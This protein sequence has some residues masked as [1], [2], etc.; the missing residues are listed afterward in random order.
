[1]KRVNFFPT[2]IRRLFL[3]VTLTASVFI[4]SGCHALIP[5]PAAAGLDSK[6]IKPKPPAVM[7]APPARPGIEPDATWHDWILLKDAVWEIGNTGV[8]VTVPAGF[9]T[10]LASSPRIAWPFGL[11]PTETYT[12][13]AIIHDYLYWTG[14]CSRAQSDNLLLI[15]M[16][17]SKVPQAQMLA[18]YKAVDLFGQSAWQE[19]EN[20]RKDGLVKVVPTEWR[21]QPTGIKWRDV[22]KEMKK[23]GVT[24]SEVVRD[25]AFCKYGN[26]QEVP[27]DPSRPPT[28]EDKEVKIPIPSL[29]IAKVNG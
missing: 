7:P 24:E 3:S 17:E 22:R 21:D 20:Q 13:A 14:I 4:F 5:S 12:G 18:V 1:M 8:T 10:D 28:R 11:S 16:K 23:N 9:M 2:V 26:S 25:Q 27:F 15:A 29:R 19:N 6:L